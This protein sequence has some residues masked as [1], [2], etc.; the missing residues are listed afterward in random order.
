G[1]LLDLALRREDAGAR[2]PDALIDPLALRLRESE[3]ILPAER[4]AAAGGDDDEG[5][6][7]A[8]QRDVRVALEVAAQFI[9]DRGRQLLVLLQDRGAPRRD[10]VRPDRRRDRGP[11]LLDEP[12]D[13]RT[14]LRAAPRRQ[15]Q[16]ARAAGVP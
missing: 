16:H 3:V 1:Q 8:D 14:E 7:A 13:V 15:D 4:L 9:Q 6:R 12:A 2:L 11:Q 5:V 10:R